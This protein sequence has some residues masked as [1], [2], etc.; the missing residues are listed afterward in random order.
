MRVDGIR[1]RVAIAIVAYSHQPLHFMPG[2]KIH[3]LWWVA[4][5]SALAP[6][7]RNDKTTPPHVA[8]REERRES[9]RRRE[10]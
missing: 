3:E 9:E 2:I 6:S 1:V 10:R 4:D 7:M 5:M 8:A